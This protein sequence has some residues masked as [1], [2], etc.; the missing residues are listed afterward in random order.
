MGVGGWMKRKKK[1][2]LQ[3]VPNELVNILT[4]K[5]ISPIHK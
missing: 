2:D 5:K 1:L 3:R 4:I